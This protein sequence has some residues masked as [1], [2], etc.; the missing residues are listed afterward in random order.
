MK[1]IGRDHAKW[2]PVA[3]ASYRLLPAIKLRQQVASAALCALPFALVALQVSGARADA[4]VKL[5]PMN[6]FD[7]EDGVAAVSRPRDCTLCRS[8]GVGGVSCSPRG[9]RVVGVQRVCAGVGVVGAGGAGARV[10][11]L[12]LCV[13]RIEPT[14]V[15]LRCLRAVS[16]ESVGAVPS[17]TLFRTAAAI[18]RGMDRLWAARCTPTDCGVVLSAKCTALIAELDAIGASE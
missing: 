14:S 8:V 5:C 13:A 16:V 4:L 17:R 12:H 7:V 6:V 9:S 3:T 2:S 1:G 15:S 11:S 10:Q 18:L